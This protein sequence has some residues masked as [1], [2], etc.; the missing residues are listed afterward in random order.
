MRKSWS[1]STGG[2]RMPNRQ[3]RKGTTPTHIILKALIYRTR[4]ENIKDTRVK[5]HIKS[6]PLVQ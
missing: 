4:G 5:L 3:D 2:F 1:S 6:N